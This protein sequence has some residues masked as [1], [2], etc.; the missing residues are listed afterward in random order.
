MIFHWS[1]IY[2]KQTARSQAAQLLVAI[3]SLENKVDLV[4]TT[5]SSFTPS[6]N[7]VVCSNYALLF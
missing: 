6:G 2:S 4:A 5:T 7:L 3:Y 1:D